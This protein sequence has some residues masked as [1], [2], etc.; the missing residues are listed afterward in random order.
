MCFRKR[1]KM[2]LFSTTQH[3]GAS[4]R[5]MAHGGGALLLI[6]FLSSCGS[7]SPASSSTPHPTPI[8]TPTPT[9]TPVTPDSLGCPSPYPP[10]ISRLHIKVQYKYKDYW[11]VDSTPLV[12]PDAL[13]CSI[14]GYTDARQFCSIRMEGAADRA[15]CELWAAGMSNDTPPRRGPTFTL[16]TP[17]GKEH[18]CSGET[19]GCAHDPALG[20]WTIRAYLGGVYTVCVEDGVCESTQVERGL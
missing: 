3:A 18:Y 14:I 20:A 8:A 9:P 1:E 15:A 17:D 6:V 13:Y 5:R 12:G 19:E 16:T 11:T 2:R 10:P 7:G 4:L